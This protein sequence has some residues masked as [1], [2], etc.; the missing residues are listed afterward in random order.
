MMFT[1]GSIILDLCSKET[2]QFTAG[3]H[4]LHTATCDWTQTSMPTRMPGF[5]IS[6]QWHRTVYFRA[7]L[8]VCTSCSPDS[9]TALGISW[10]Q[11]KVY[12]PRQVFMWNPEH[13]RVKKL[14]LW[15]SLEN[16]VRQAA[17]QAVADVNSW[18]VSV[19]TQI[20][21]RLSSSFPRPDHCFS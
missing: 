5:L 3:S 21:A 20:K 19:L 16:S 17:I 9:T 10:A 7:A 12:L 13:T 1:V 15:C 14:F 8:H 11:D 4:T 18:A 2:P 6:R